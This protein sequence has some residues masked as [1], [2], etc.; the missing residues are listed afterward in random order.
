MYEEGLLYLVLRIMTEMID[1]GKLWCELEDEGYIPI[2]VGYGTEGHS[3]TLANSTH[4]VTGYGQTLKE[5]I[6]D[7]RRGLAEFAHCCPTCGRKW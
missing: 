1:I 7:A 3:M 5:A 6:E 4:Q 2:E